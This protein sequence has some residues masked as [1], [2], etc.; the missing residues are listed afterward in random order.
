[1]RGLESLP[2]SRPH[3]Q[4]PGHLI[5]ISLRDRAHAHAF[6]EVLPKQAVE[7]LV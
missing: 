4:L 3:I 5:A 6:W 7:V 1:V 2:L